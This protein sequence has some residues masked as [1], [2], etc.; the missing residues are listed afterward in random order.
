MP[1]FR[2]RA[3]AVAVLLALGGPARAAAQ[4]TRQTFVAVLDQGGQPVL[5]LTPDEFSLDEDGAPRTITR[6]S[7]A[8]DP[9][10]VVLLVDTG[11]QT[12]Q[13]ITQIREALHTF[14]DGLPPDHEVVL[15]T[16]GRQ[17]RVR[18]QPT[19]DRARL[20]KA[21]D[22]IFPD[23]GSATVLLDSLRESWD[24]FLKKADN[25][26]PV[27]VIVT[28]DGTEGSNA[29]RQEEY[30]RFMRDILA[31]GV[32]VHAAVVQQRDGSLSA[33]VSPAQVALN[34][35]QNT[36]GKFDAL[37]A[38]TGLSAEM[39]SIAARLTEDYDYI[40]TRYLIR[41]ESRSKNGDAQIG[42]R[43]ARD[44]VTLQMSPDRRSR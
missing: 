41:Y 17:L 10:R 4:T 1:S 26:W 13:I 28:T 24:R 21:V 44:D 34:L 23:K 27:F 31:A 8:D 11:D 32:S 33:Q 22:N 14:F 19:T 29:T 2:T 15:I 9:M 20:H 36:G 12:Q 42:L 5:D 43:V 39:D 40:R 18:E 35:T 25:R 30:D 37:A 7:L 38:S 16:T 3:A 6:A